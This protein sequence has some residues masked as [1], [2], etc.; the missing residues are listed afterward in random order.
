MQIGFSS[1][2]SLIS[3]A[4]RYVTGGKVSHC[5]LV[6]QSDQLGGL[7]VLE[8]VNDGYHIRPFTY[9]ND[10]NNTLILVD[11]KLP[12]DGVLPV[13]ARWLGETYD[14]S[15][16]AGIP[17][18]GLGRFLKQKWHNPLAT[19][20]TLFCSEAI[21]RGLQVIGYPGATHLVAEDTSPQD[22]LDFLTK[23]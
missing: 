7:F 20:N 16:A 14:W 11:P 21:V 2:T 12:I 9:T 8:A 6:F 4:I 3:R 13:C 10:A 22:L 18:V 23:I 1:S 5:F 17:L 15:V 19:K